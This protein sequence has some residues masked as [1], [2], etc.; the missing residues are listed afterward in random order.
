[1]LTIHENIISHSLAREFAKSNDILLAHCYV[2]NKR[3][4]SDFVRIKKS[5]LYHEYEIKSTRSDFLKDFTKK[6]KHTKIKIGDSGLASFT[7]VVKVGEV[8]IEDIPNYC[9]F[10][11]YEEV[12]GVVRFKEIKKAPRLRGAKKLSNDELFRICKNISFRSY[13]KDKDCLG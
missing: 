13:L 9:G 2:W 10:W 8:G 1:M 4:E 5:M 7:F 6:G 11:E 12:H 3:F